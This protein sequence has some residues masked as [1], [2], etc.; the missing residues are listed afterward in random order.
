MLRRRTGVVS[1]EINYVMDKVEVIYDSN[2][3][4]LNE[5]RR[6]ISGEEKDTRLA[7]NPSQI[8]TRGS[9]TSKHEHQTSRSGLRAAWRSYALPAYHDVFV[10]NSSRFGLKNLSHVLTS[11]LQHT[12]V[13]VPPI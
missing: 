4:S 3:V 10:N 12:V 2:L 9:D 8:G 1:F 7:A 6:T 5:L 11:T 13:G